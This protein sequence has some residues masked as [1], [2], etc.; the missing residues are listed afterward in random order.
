VVLA[1]TANPYYALRGVRPG[2]R[3]ASVARSLRAG[4]GFRVGLNTWYLT[5]NGS[6]R[7]VLKV[8]HGVIEEIG[9]ADKRL[10]GSR[11]GGLRF[12]EGFQNL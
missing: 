7:G 3:L 4:R 2:R 6:S 12:F 1:L 5:P 9:I 8:R 10:T 11:R